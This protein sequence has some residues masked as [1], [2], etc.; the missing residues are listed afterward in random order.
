M[1]PINEALG[2]ASRISCALS[3]ITFLFLDLRTVLARLRFVEV[4]LREESAP[5]FCPSG[6][7]NFVVVK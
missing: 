4:M 6:G 7:R 3:P 2:N 5:P 1:K